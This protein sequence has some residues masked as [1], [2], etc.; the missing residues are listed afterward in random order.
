MAD[1][2]TCE[3]CGKTRTDEPDYHPMQVLTGQPFGWYS[4]NDGELC[5]DDFTRLYELG[6]GPRR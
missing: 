5:P 4:G 6:N 1:D 2:V 3:M